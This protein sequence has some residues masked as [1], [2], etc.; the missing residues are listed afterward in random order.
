MA[1]DL[2]LYRDREGGIG[3]FLKTQFTPS[4]FFSM[5]KEK[6]E[7]ESLSGLFKLGFLET[8]LIVTSEEPLQHL[9]ADL[10]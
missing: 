2:P 6:F 8:L 5:A 10:P 1:A 3:N 4:F 7:T 9:T